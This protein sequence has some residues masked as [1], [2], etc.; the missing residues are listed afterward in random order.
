[1]CQTSTNLPIP[2]QRTSEGAWVCS[3]VAVCSRCSRLVTSWC[4]R[5]GPGSGGSKGPVTTPRGHG[6]KMSS[7]LQVGVKLRMTS[8]PI[9]LESKRENDKFKGFARIG[10]VIDR[11]WLKWLQLKL[12]GFY[13][14][15]PIARKPSWP[16][17][18]VAKSA[19]LILTQAH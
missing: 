6:L 9:P 1:M 15:R 4:S 18:L 16:D 11:N 5:V 14:P 13:Y 10:C 7:R 3:W 12:P 2:L 17:K 19:R 8:R